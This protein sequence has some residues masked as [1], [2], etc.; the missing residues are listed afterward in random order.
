MDSEGITSCVPQP[1]R[2][3][4]KGGQAGFLPQSPLFLSPPAVLL[5]RTDSHLPG[6]ALTSRNEN[7]LVQEGS[8]QSSAP[9]T[10][11]RLGSPLGLCGGE[12]PGRR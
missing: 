3:E 11:G 8:F 2:Q 10:L 4:T 6:S 12:P 9:H 7:Q 1:Q 5:R